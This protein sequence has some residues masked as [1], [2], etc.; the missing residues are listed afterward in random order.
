MPVNLV[1]LVYGKI[2]K[3][4]P[5]GARMAEVDERKEAPKG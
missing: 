5:D 3:G 2:T 1:A 4:N